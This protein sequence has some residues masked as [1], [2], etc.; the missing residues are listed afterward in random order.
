MIG[1][2]DITERERETERKKRGGRR[3]T[4]ESLLEHTAQSPPAEGLI[5]RT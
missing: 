4:D 1:A 3:K 2:L 5:S